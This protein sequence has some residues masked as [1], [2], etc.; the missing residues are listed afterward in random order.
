MSDSPSGFG[1]L[2]PEL[3][4]RGPRADPAGKTPWSAPASAVAKRSRGQRIAGWAAAAT[5]VCVLLAAG[6]FW[7]IYHSIFGNIAH[8]NA[9]DALA[10]NGIHRPAA[11]AK[12]ENFLLIGSDTRAGADGV[13]QAAKGSAD[14]TSGQRSD[15]MMLVHVPS[16]SAKASIISF[17]RDSWVTIP[18]WTDSKGAHHPEHQSKLNA[19]FS[20]GGAPLLVATLEKLSGI[21]VNHVVQIDFTGFKNMVNALGGITVCVKTTRH[22]HDSGDNLTAG[23]NHLIMGDAALAFVRDRKA[24]P[25]GDID[26][27]A[28]Q[29]YFLSVVLHKVLSANTLTDPARLYNFAKAAAKSMTTDNGFGILAMKT[30]GTRLRHLDPA[31]VTFLQVPVLNSA[32]RIAG[33]SV[34]ELNPAQLPAVFAAMKDNTGQPKVPAATS[35]AAAP[36]TPP[37]PLTVSPSQIRVRVANGSGRAH[38]AVQTATSLKAGGFTAVTAGNA[39]NTAVTT[40]FYG[41]GKAASA[42]TLA[43]AV[44]GSVIKLKTSLGSTLELVIGDNFTSVVKVAAGKAAAAT[45]TA[46]T[47]APT[48]GTAAAVSA[49]VAKAPTA[50][51]A[52]CAP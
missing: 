4:P 16:G 33:Q 8:I 48:A 11:D 20:E 34:V 50:A 9:F 1:D 3:N 39:V 43:A 29:Q 47:T 38:L 32:A 26:R 28:D 31:H 40:V 52:V 23:A 5:S 14:Y 46:P 10:K 25:G 49:L 22:D 7:V 2:P 21:R 35:T 41:T 6:G 42:R 37:V 24:L 30:L 19:A 12:A 13:Y 17:P 36:T 27:I 18:Q 45:T 15:T 51:S 44:P